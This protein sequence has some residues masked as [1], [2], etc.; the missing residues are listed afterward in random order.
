MSQIL[1]KYVWILGSERWGETESREILKEVRGTSKEILVDQPVESSYSFNRA[2]GSLREAR[3]TLGKLGFQ[4]TG[5]LMRCLMLSHASNVSKNRTDTY[6]WE[7][8]DVMEASISSGTLRT[9]EIN[10]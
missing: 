10:L 3:V 4:G 6:R 5:G 2:P 8:C 9:N 7:I 1:N